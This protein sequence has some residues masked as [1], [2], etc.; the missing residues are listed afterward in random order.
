MVGPRV[1]RE[2]TN[3]FCSILLQKLVVEIRK[4]KA[5]VGSSCGDA[6]K[7]AGEGVALHGTPGALGVPWPQFSCST[8]IF[9]QFLVGTLR[10]D[11]V[12]STSSYFL[13]LHL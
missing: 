4:N 5:V 1:A 7:Y 9:R 2:D 13:M 10:T 3:V 12:R 8:A 6:P 11:R